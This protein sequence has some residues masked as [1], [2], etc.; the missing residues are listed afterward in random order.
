[1]GVS[2]MLG[3]KEVRQEKSKRSI[4]K[5]HHRG[6][7]GDWKIVHCVNKGSSGALVKVSFVSSRNESQSAKARGPSADKEADMGA[8]MPRITASTAHSQQC[9]LHILL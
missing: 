4:Q 3:A 7:A 2:K 8:A 6:S 5:C 1:M 9:A